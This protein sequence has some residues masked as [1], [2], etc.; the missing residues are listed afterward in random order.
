MPLKT[1]VKMKLSLFLLFYSFSIYAS[2]NMDGACSAKLKIF[3]LSKLEMQNCKLAGALVENAP[4]IKEYQKNQ[5]YEKLSKKLATQL[6]QNLEDI[7]LIDQFYSSNKQDLTMGSDKL[8]NSC[9]VDHIKNIESKCG[10]KK[11]ELLKKHFPTKGGNLV[12]QIINKFSSVRNIGASNASKTCPLD[13]SSGAF[14]LSSQLSNEA[15]LNIISKI[16][17][18][19]TEGNLYFNQFPQLKLIEKSGPK[20]LKK[21][22]DYISSFNGKPEEAKAYLSQFLF[23]NENKPE[24]AQGLASQCESINRNVETFLCNDLEQVGSL[25]PTT[26]NALFSLE[27]KTKLEDMFDI[28]NIKTNEGST[29]YAA[30]A[31]QCLAQRDQNKAS[32]PKAELSVDS[33]YKNFTTNIRPANKT[34]DLNTDVTNFCSLYTCSDPASKSTSSCKT[35]GHLNFEDFKKMNDCS[36][37]KAKCSEQ[38]ASIY[39][40]LETMKFEEEYQQL[41]YPEN[42]LSST[43]TSASRMSTF[44]QNFLGVEGTLFVEGKKI[45]TAAIAERSQEFVERKLDPTPITHEIKPLDKTPTLIANNSTIAG[46]GERQTIEA[47]NTVIPTTARIDQFAS[48]DSLSALP[49]KKTI[50][51]KNTPSKDSVSPAVDFDKETEIKKLRA[52]LESVTNSIKGNNSEKLATVT[53]NNSRYSSA[54]L[55]GTSKSEPLKGLNTSEKDRLEQYQKNLNAWENRLQ[56]WQADLSN[57]GRSTASSIETPQAKK[58]ESLES[59]A[60]RSLK[61]DSS[62]LL[63]AGGSVSDKG[64]N[65]KGNASVANGSGNETPE[66]IVNSEDLAELKIETLKKM[67]INSKSAFIMKIRY[68]NKMYNVPVKTLL[69]KGKDILVPL[70]SDKNNVLSK[71]VLESPLF[72]DYKDQQIE[73]Q[74]E[75]AGFAAALN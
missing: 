14:V 30:Y 21:F 53:D 36:N 67:G 2:P 6:E 39:A 73:R 63:S 24:L 66:A 25:D 9:K 61:S 45:T 48:N 5:I 55:G 8:K 64:K 71:I 74:K 42:K 35:K 38:N 51:I 65:A 54:S 56:N 57:N 46:L 68:Q 41:Q 33:W 26:S 17:T 32:M 16:K 31:F 62:L 44:S 69:Y 15:A 28:P 34:A 47:Q 59:V 50:T 70:L 43:D 72:S 18:G 20:I 13:K 4:E 29:F 12:E 40:Y 19:S 3:E 37:L 1:E 75:R 10:G 58:P 11:L 27:P 22:K 7:A 52:D 49:S 23:N 60:N